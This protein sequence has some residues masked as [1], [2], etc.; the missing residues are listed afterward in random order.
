MPS[1]IAIKDRKRKHCPSAARA[2]GTKQFKEE[3]IP[4]VGEWKCPECDFCNRFWSKA[5]RRPKHI[6][7]GT[8]TVP[9]TI[10]QEDTGKHGFPHQPK[11]RDRVCSICDY[12]TIAFDNECRRQDTQNEDPNA[13]DW[14][15]GWRRNASFIQ[16]DDGRHEVCEEPEFVGDWWCGPCRAWKPGYVTE[17]NWSGYDKK[18]ACKCTI[19]KGPGKV[20]RSRT[21]TDPKY[22]LKR[23]FCQAAGSTFLR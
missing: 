8:K 10:I 16:P 19:Q 14:C 11:I 13:R 7:T 6:C 21:Y 9:T 12:V 22:F 1:H 18:T 20:K 5:C 3:Y 17:C 2:S 4:K 15:K 23:G